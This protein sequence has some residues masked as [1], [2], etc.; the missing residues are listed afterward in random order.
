M[1]TLENGHMDHY[2]PQ[3]L[4]RNWCDENNEIWCFDKRSQKV[5]KKG[6][7]CFA[8]EK[9]LNKS[10]VIKLDLEATVFSELDNKHGGNTNAILLYSLFGKHKR[11]PNETMRFFIELC[12]W[13]SVRNKRVQGWTDVDEFKSSLESEHVVNYW[14][15]AALKKAIHLEFC[16]LC[17]EGVMGG[18]V[19]RLMKEFYCF[20]VVSDEKFVTSD[21]PVQEFGNEAAEGW[22]GCRP[23]AGDECSLIM[24]PLHP[25]FMFVATR[26][27]E[28]AACHRHFV[29]DED[30]VEA[31]YDAHINSEAEELYFP[32]PIYEP[33]NL[34][35]VNIA[36][37]IVKKSKDLPCA[38][39]LQQHKELGAACIIHSN[40]R[41]PSS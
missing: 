32:Y 17:D 9:D 40:W 8:R 23:V 29:D 1:T 11:V 25:S 28:Y 26:H 22:L 36:D 41:G 37:F 20:F 19:K 33:R 21:L 16:K 39:D 3:W 27:E 24:F 7:A 15:D 18:E 34:P 31:N 12:L 6:T 35:A 4:M 14:D 13:T 2:F 5:R 10:D 38:I 30:L